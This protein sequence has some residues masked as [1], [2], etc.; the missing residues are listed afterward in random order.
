MRLEDNPAL[1]AAAATGQPVIPVFILPADDEE[2]GWPLMGA[3]RYWLHGS[4]NQM[5]HSLAGIGSALVL[6]DG[7]GM[8]SG[9]T[10]LQ[11]LTLVEET[12]ASDVFWCE[13]Y[14]P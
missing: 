1:C 3:A 10:L 9:G 14:E 11:L 8:G 7:G 2:G 6:R 12:G 4:L 13:S 5:Q